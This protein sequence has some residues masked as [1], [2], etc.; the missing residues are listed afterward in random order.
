MEEL[1][2]NGVLDF[3]YQYCFSRHLVPGWGT[4][5]NKVKEYNPNSVLAVTL[6]ETQMLNLNIYFIYF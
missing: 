2:L 6:L 3:F 5:M 1:T 4:E